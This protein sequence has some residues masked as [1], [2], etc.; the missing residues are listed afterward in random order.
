MDQEIDGG[1][2]KHSEE[3]T[4]TLEGEL[5]QTVINNDSF[6]NDKD[7]DDDELDESDDESSDDVGDYSEEEVFKEDDVVLD[8]KELAKGKVATLEQSGESIDTGK[9]ER[10]LSD[11]QF[12]FV[13]TDVEDYNVDKEVEKAEASEK[14]IALK[15]KESKSELAEKKISRLDIAPL[16]CVCRPVNIPSVKSST[17][18]VHQTEPVVGSWPQRSTGNHLSVHWSTGEPFRSKHH[19]RPERLAMAEGTRSLPLIHRPVHHVGSYDGSP[20]SYSSPCR[21]SVAESTIL[22]EDLPVIYRRRGC[23][24]RVE[25]TSITDED[26]AEFERQCVGAFCTFSYF[27]T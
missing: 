16:Q 2:P 9:I 13:L 6:D 8:V 21:P 18:I 10:Q 14:E 17:N 3:L 15:S 23:T 5:D 24:L 4:E 22:E 25:I 11:I 12:N 1:V 20:R 19:V 7:E 27:L 26:I